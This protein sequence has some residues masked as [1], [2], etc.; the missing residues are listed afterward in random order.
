MLKKRK[1][2][3]LLSRGRSPLLTTAALLLLSSHG[4]TGFVSFAKPRASFFSLSASKSPKRKHR[5]RCRRSRPNSRKLADTPHQQPIFQPQHGL[6]DHESSIS[7]SVQRERLHESIDCKHF[8]NCADCTVKSDVSNIPVIQSARSFFSSTFSRRHRRDVISKK[9]PWAVKEYDDGFF[10]V[11]IPSKLTG[12]RTQA[13]LVA[14]AKG[15]IWSNEG[16]SFGLYRQGSHDVEPI[17]EGAIH[18]PAIRRAIQVLEETT[19]YTQT[20]CSSDE[21]LR[22]IQLQVERETGKV[23]LTLIWNEEHP[24]FAQPHLSRLVKGLNARASDLWHSIWCHCNNGAGNN[25]FT[26]NQRRWHRL[27][28]PEFHREPIPGADD[29]WLY[30][31]P[32]TFRQGNMDGFDILARDVAKL[33]PGGSAVCE[34]YAGVGVLGLSALA[35][36]ANTDTPLQWIRCSDENP[37][38]TRCF[39]L[40]VNSLRERIRG[41]KRSRQHHNGRNEGFSIDELT[42]KL[43]SHQQDDLPPQQRQPKTSYLVASASNALQM[44]QAVGAQVLIV[45]PP[46]KGLEDD[47]LLELCKPLNPYQAFCTES[48]FLALAGEKH[49]I[50]WVNDV[51]VLVYVS[52]RFDALARDCDKLIKNGW[53]LESAKGYILYPGG[54]HVETVAMFLRK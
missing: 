28:G 50:N 11:V 47:V 37:A 10:E 39:Q 18:H 40:G 23:C 20:P 13:T 42:A 9:L 7:S 33:I 24:K 35:Y 43:E 36:H 31:S 2:C 17:S 14:S 46:R 48:D 5:K 1:D 27:S 52:C 19:A 30:F 53:L 12:C 3:T 29:G 25:I 34:L 21:G 22:Y 49:M 51:K 16:C 15:S 45:D 32:L 8:S 4:A 44:G 54:N 26:R 38:N 41:T 6:I